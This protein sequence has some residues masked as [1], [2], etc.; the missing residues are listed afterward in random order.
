MRTCPCINEPLGGA[1]LFT[2]VE[3]INNVALE[4]SGNCNRRRIH[5]PSNDLVKP[6]PVILL[7][8]V[9]TKGLLLESDGCHKD[10]KFSQKFSQKYSQKLTS[11]VVVTLLHLD[12]LVVFVELIVRPSKKGAHVVTGWFVDV[13]M[14][15]LLLTPIANNEKSLEHQL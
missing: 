11:D 2:F 13:E 10:K 3:L 7:V 15:P 6:D 5:Q 8:E 14:A 1:G 9:L 4:Q 12:W